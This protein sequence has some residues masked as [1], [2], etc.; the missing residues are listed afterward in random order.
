M[1]QSLCTWR[2]QLQLILDVALL[3]LGR[4]IAAGR[5]RRVDQVKRRGG[6]GWENEFVAK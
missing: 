1:L 5:V 2:N 3:D 4:Q 6:M